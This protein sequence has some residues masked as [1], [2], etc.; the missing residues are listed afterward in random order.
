MRL[1]TFV[2]NTNAALEARQKLFLPFDLFDSHLHTRK[3][4]V[5]CFIEMRTKQI[6]WIHSTPGRVSSVCSMTLPEGHG[7]RI[8]TYGGVQINGRFHLPSLAH[9]FD[10]I[11]IFN[12]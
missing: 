9:D 11:V 6:C 10:D 3:S 5:A 8:W 2:I 4:Q 7:D 1:H 12:T